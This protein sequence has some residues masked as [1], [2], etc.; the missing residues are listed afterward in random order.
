MA[1][2]GN[3][4]TGALHCEPPGTNRGTQ[5]IDFTARAGDPETQVV[6]ARLQTPLGQLLRAAADGKL[7]TTFP[8]ITFDDEAAVGVV[9]ASEGYP[10]APKT[11]AQINGV[12]QA[13]K[14]EDVAVLHAGT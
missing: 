14:L 1:D 11:G 9:V 6:L 7:R 12:A 13:A 3:P 2:R 5:V 8:T 10:N 4:F